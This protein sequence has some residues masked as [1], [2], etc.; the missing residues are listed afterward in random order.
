MTLDLLLESLG[1]N[2]ASSFIYDLI[3]DIF[4]KNR[5][6]SLSDFKDELLKYIEIEKAEIASDSIIEFLAE[7]GDIVILGSKIYSKESIVMTS[8]VGT[9]FQVKDG[10]SNT[11]EQTSIELGVGASITGQNGAEIRQ[12]KDGISFRV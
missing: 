10:S 12:S 11:T 8:S 1:L 5:E 9:K 2:L 3:K 7:T 6:L 4:Q